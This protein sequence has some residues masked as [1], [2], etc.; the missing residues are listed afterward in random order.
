MK[1]TLALLS[2]LLV[3]TC[4]ACHRDYTPKPVAY[5]RFDFPDHQYARCDTAP[6][7]FTFE[8]AT[9][10]NVTLKRNTPREIYLDLGYPQY[11]GYVFLT[12]KPLHGPED[13]RAQVDTS[14]EL[15]KQH[16]DYSTGVDEHR[17][18]NP[19]GHVYATTYRL[20]GS[21]V[22]STYQFWAT[23]STRHFLRGALFLDCVP[24]NDSLAPLLDYLQAD[25][26]HL[27]ESLEWR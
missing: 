17:F 22:A 12:Y 26:D 4:A 21:S 13:L 7:P 18:V 14:Y 3:L 8:R 1:R 11:K 15:M 19:A 6:L 20:K 27:L 23:D 24:N 2:L 5:L 16:F 25:M 9:L 10:A